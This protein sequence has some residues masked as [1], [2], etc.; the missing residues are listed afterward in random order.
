VAPAPDFL[1]ALVG[2]RR[3]LVQRG[4]AGNLALRRED[5]GRAAAGCD[6]AVEVQRASLEK[7]TLRLVL[8]YI[9][10]PEVGGKP[11]AK[12]GPVGHVRTATVSGF[13]NGAAA[14]DVNGVVDRLAPTPEAYLA[15]RGVT[16]DLAADPKEPAVAAVV[17]PNGND[18]E[19]QLGRQVT[20]WPKRLLAVQPAFSDVSGRVRQES[21]IEFK[22]IVGVD[23]RLHQ[24]HVVSGLGPSHEEIVLRALSV[25]RY[26]PARNKANDRVPAHVE[27]RLRF[28]IY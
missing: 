14:A 4:D 12:C 17:P 13:E 24:P 6:V 3:V 8:E 23:G 26:E 20:A 19:R 10:A 9:G 25:W 27:E 5:A 16:F 22:A 11:G 2:Q 18:E 21:E 1:Q 15:A 28:K 7:G